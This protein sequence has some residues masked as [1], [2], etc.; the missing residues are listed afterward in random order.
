MPSPLAHN[1]SVS[2]RPPVRQSSGQSGRRDDV[3][4]TCHELTLSRRDDTGACSI[5]LQSRRVSSVLIN[6]GPCAFSFSRFWNC[7]NDCTPSR[8]AWCLSHGA[9]D[10][11]SDGPRYR[12]SYRLFIGSHSGLGA[13]GGA[14]RHTLDTSPPSPTTSFQRLT[15]PRVLLQPGRISQ[16]SVHATAAPC[17][18]VDARCVEQQQSEASLTG[19]QPRAAICSAI[20]L[21]DH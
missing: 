12:Y 20:I 13:A 16:T 9:A 17:L 10:W 18:G 3:K 6:P 5:R 14:H 8:V 15:A 19:G 4:V 2:Y 21:A 1:Q 7:S 11:D